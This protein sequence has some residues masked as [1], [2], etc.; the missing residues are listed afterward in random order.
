M[1]LIFGASACQRI[2][3]K[4]EGFFF[5]FLVLSIRHINKHTT[6]LKC[7]K[8]SKKAVEVVSLSETSLEIS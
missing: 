2:T 6:L 4:E 5:N 3:E 7:C 1:A 8:C